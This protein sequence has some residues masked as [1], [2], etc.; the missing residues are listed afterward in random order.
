VK[1]AAYQYVKKWSV[2]GDQGNVWLERRLT[3]RD[4]QPTDQVCASRS[5]SDDLP[6][7]AYMLC[8]DNYV[9]PPFSRTEIY[10]AHMSRGSASY[11]SIY[12]ARACAQ[13]QPF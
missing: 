6:K 1:Q 11:P 3:I 8:V 2:F 7:S 12:A 13:Q 4:L 10:A 9:G 5:N